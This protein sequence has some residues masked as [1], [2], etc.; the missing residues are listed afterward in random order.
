MA[1]LA[2]GSA[3]SGCPVR[4]VTQ[5]PATAQVEM[6]RLAVAAERGCPVSTT[7]LI[8]RSKRCTDPLTASLAAKAAAGDQKAKAE[9]IKRVKMLGASDQ[10]PP[11]PTTIA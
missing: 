5:C 1:E 6:A 4:A 2:A 9:L 3:A 7:Q 11:D 8:E 10:T